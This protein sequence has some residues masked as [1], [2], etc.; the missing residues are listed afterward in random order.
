MIVA[1]VDLGVRK[2]SVTVLDGDQMI[3]CHAYESKLTL[4]SAQLRDVSDF[5]FVCCE[6]GVDAI[7]VEEPLVGRSTRV[8]LQI[9]QMAGAVLSALDH[10]REPDSTQGRSYLV[11]NTSWKKAVIGVGGGKDI[12]LKVREWLDQHF[13]DYAS[14]CAGDQDCYDATCIALYAQ[15]QQQLAARIREDSHLSRATALPDGKALA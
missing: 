10:L 5:V 12:K 11:S 2:A 9:G 6:G 15:Q 7:Y 8:S 1:G 13:P 14:R 4:R 3:G